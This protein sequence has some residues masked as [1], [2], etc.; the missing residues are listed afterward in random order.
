MALKGECDG[1][2]TSEQPKLD[3]SLDW[4]RKFVKKHAAVKLANPASLESSRNQYATME[5]FEVYFAKVCILFGEN[6]YHPSMVA[7]FDETMLKWG[8][9]Y[10]T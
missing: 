8:K 4:V 3:V 9:N 6:S 7:N 5:N 10:R 2:S 1:I